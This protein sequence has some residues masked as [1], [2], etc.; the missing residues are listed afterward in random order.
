[1]LPEA[2]ASYTVPSALVKATKLPKD[3]S[4]VTAVKSS[5][6]FTATNVTVV[7]SIE[8]FGRITISEAKLFHVNMF[9][10]SAST[11]VYALGISSSNSALDSVYTEVEIYKE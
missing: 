4:A 7:N 2:L 3:N 11:D 10:Q 8:A 9:A 1:M 6:R 5:T